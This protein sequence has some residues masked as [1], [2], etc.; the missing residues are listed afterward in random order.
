MLVLIGIALQLLVT[1]IG[2]LGLAF[3]IWSWI[4]GIAERVTRIEANVVHLQQNIGGGQRG[5]LHSAKR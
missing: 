5:K 4:G 1:I 3:K 2:G